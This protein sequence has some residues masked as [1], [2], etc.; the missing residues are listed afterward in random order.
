MI[1]VNLLSDPYFFNTT[2]CK[3]LCLFLHYQTCFLLYA[4]GLPEL[5]LSLC[6]EYCGDSCKI[7]HL[8]LCKDITDNVILSRLRTRRAEGVTSCFV[9]AGWCA[10]NEPDPSLVHRQFI[11]KCPG[12]S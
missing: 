3:R 9:E 1:L 4:T 5:R 7:Y 8:G 12:I 6:S 2:P 10:M 11:H